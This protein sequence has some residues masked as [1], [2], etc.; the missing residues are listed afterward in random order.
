M[1]LCSVNPGIFK[2]PPLLIAAAVIAV[3]CA[4][5]MIRHDFVERLELMTYDWRARWAERFSPIASTNLAFV[6][7]GDESIKYVK[8]GLV[9][10][11]HYGL[12]WPRHLYGRVVSEL[13]SQGARAVA[14]DVLFEELRQD[15]EAVKLGAQSVGSDEFFAQRIAAG[16][17]VILAAQ[18]GGLPAPLFLRSALAVGDID[19]EKD[20][21]GILRRARAFQNYR[22]WNPAFQFLQDH[23]DYGVDLSNVKIE[24][25]RVVL[26]RPPPS[27]NISIPLDKNGNF[28]W[29][30][31]FDLQKLPA[32]TPR[33]D[34]PFRM[35]RVWHMGIVLAAQQLKLDLAHALL[36]L[37][38]GRITLAGTNG[39]VRVI[40]VDKDGYFYIDWCLALN[41]DRLSYA[42]IEALLGQY[43]VH[44]M[45]SSN[46]EAVD[47]ATM[48][49][50]RQSSKASGQSAN[51]H[52]KLVIIGSEASGND[53]TDRGATPLTKQTLLVSKHWNVANSVLTGRF[54]RR[55]SRP[56]ELFI[57]V[58][59]VVLAGGLTWA[60]QARA[61]ISSAWMAVAVAGYTVI[62]VFLFV[63]FRYWIP[64]VLP[65]GGGL[66][67]THFSLLAY[68]VFFEQRERRRVRSV[69]SK[70]V[71]ADV[72]TELLKSENLAIDGEQRNITVFFSDIRGFTEMTDVNRERAED[73]IKEQNLAGEE[74]EAV[75]NAEAKQT[76]DTV[77][78][79]LTII[80]DVVLKHGG[81]VDKFIGDCVMAFW[82][83]PVHN[84]H[85]ALMCVR[86]AIDTQR[87]VY[88]FNSGR[89]A[90]NRQR[91][92]QNLLLAAEGRELQPLLPTLVVGT[93]INTGVVTVGLMGSDERVN[94]TVFGREVNLASR[95]ETVSG[96][97]RIII[98]E[99]TL[100][101]VIQD[102]ATLALS[103]IPQEPV[104][105][106]GIRQAVQ[107]F[108][109]PW[110]E[111]GTVPSAA[112]QTPGTEAYNTG[113]FTAA[114]RSE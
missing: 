66:L 5:Q 6:G 32:G 12:Y 84:P 56:M 100:A 54:I 60:W 112:D 94:Y 25:D 3:V 57:I 101:E 14:F 103:C 114:E 62:A 18:Q 76:L 17:N 51:F 104:K 33:F 111:E 72:V 91:E 28:D 49:D 58:L 92:A 53:L 80:A 108:E 21:D 26:L 71:S 110:R 67:G 96:R 45:H 27:E 16:G 41:D 79:Y 55:S 77:N 68:L 23:E 29:A 36:D 47:L 93:G 73:F 75:R 24:K 46:A 52:G 69:F 105:V 98:S 89:E 43:Q 10:D 37:D 59:M 13:E 30:D 48:W 44:E 82:G 2:R 42:P 86:A 88:N 81:T 83:A 7:I 70:V 39:V 106:K 90:E 64:L 40:P 8:K 35:E 65:V 31:L 61:W 22:I 9:D 74:A 95:L 20:S 11:K 38:H 109:V 78:E 97:S 102:D 34:K 1:Y 63:E 50:A 15:H 99:A 85:H 113:Y 87:A 107:I 4:V 19:A